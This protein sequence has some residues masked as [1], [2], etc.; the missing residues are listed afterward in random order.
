MTQILLHTK[1]CAPIEE[2]FNLSR[3]IDF[4]LKSA[5]QTNESVISGKSKGLI[6]LNE[7]VTWRG[8][9]FGFNLKHTSKITQ[10]NHPNSFTDLMIEGQ[11]KYFIHQHLFFEKDYGTLMVDIIKY[12]TPYGYFGRLF[13]SV[14]LKSHLT[15]FLSTRNTAIKIELE[16]NPIS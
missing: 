12:K 15:Q 8:K 3:S 5:K 11:F 16:K 4:H 6:N 2:V 10:L 1:I 9:H 7:T 14:L 13:D